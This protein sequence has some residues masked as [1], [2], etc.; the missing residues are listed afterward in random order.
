MLEHD[1]EF[2]GKVSHA[3][4]SSSVRHF[5]R[6]DCRVISGTLRTNAD[7]LHADYGS[8]ISF[9]KFAADQCR[10][11][12]NAPPG[13]RQST[14]HYV[15][16][17]RANETSLRELLAAAQLESS[18]AGPPGRADTLSKAGGG[19][20]NPPTCNLRQPR[21]R[22][23]PF[24]AQVDRPGLSAPSP[25]LVRCGGASRRQ[26]HAGAEPYRGGATWSRFRPEEPARCNAKVALGNPGLSVGRSRSPEAPGDSSTN[27][28]PDYEVAGRLKVLRDV[29]S[30]KDF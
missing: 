4:A 9:A 12:P 11:N 20:W 15:Q 18:H 19:Y 28:R 27:N 16:R 1:A 13:N 7:G 21:P 17:T 8:Y 29:V 22:D 25:G 5:T 3:L 6:T 26:S 2:T 30:N 23:G 24:T 14:Q 10:L